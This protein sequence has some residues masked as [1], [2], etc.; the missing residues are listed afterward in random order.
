MVTEVLFS[1]I[2]YQEVINMRRIIRLNLAI[3]VFCVL[4]INTAFANQLNWQNAPG[5]HGFSVLLENGETSSKDVIHQY[6]RGDYLSEASLEV[7]NLQNGT[8]QII[9][10]T[11]AHVN[12]DRIIQTIFVDVW[13]ED[14]EDW[15]MLD[16]WD[17][18]RTKEEVEDEELY[19]FT[20]T[21]NIYDYEVG[22]YYRAR[23]L[24]GVEIYDELEACA[25]ETD[26]VLL[27][28]LWN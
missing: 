14:S 18:E 19:I 15:V 13:D 10:T 8:L 3:M 1:R 26:G 24:H 7:A 16:S 25:T 12:V 28:D 2:C 21:I 6:A 23:G 9:A 27:T 22:R 20:A 17:F 5:H 4:M 11:F